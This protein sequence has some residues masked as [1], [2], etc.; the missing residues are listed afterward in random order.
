MKGLR[1]IALAYKNEMQKNKEELLEMSRDEI[2]NNLNFL[3]FLVF[4][5]KLKSDTK[6]VI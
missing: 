4:E 6:E 3:G 2:E 1:I 5:N